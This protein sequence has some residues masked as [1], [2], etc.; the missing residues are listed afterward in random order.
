MRKILFIIAFFAV[1][2]AFYA[3]Q[4]EISVNK[5]EEGVLQ[6][7]HLN[8][9]IK[10]LSAV[11]SKRHLKADVEDM[12]YVAVQVSIENWTKE[13]YRF[14]KDFISLPLADMDQVAK[15]ILKE[16]TI[17]SLGFKIAGFIFWPLGIPGTIDNLLSFKHYRVLQ[18]KWEAL[19][20][21]EESIAP[22][23]TYHRIFFVPSEQYTSSFAIMLQ[24]QETLEMETFQVEGKE[25]LCLEPRHQIQ[26]N[27]YLTHDS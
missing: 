25:A 16:S 26:E 12:G 22:Y 8:L 9:S 19:A 15:Q 20:V 21:K 11:E 4:K 23:S 13:T 1:S 24:N 17:R 6:E 7:D 18:E 3:Q 5:I 2:F 27:Y 10:T 14:S